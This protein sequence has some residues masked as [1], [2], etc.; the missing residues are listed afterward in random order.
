M[1]LPRGNP[2]PGLERATQSRPEKAQKGHNG[3]SR[4][5]SCT[6]SIFHV[7]ET[8]ISGWV[9]GPQFKIRPPLRGL[10]TLKLPRLEHAL[11]SA[12]DSHRL[13][14]VSA[15]AGYGKSTLLGDWAR[16]SGLNCA[17]LSLDRFDNKPERLFH[18]VV[19]ALQ[20]AASKLPVPGNHVLLALDQSLARDRAASYDLLLGALEHLTE[21]IVLVIDDTH[22]A[23][24]D[25]AQGIV[26]VLAASAPT[27]LR[28]VLSG[29]GHPSIQLERLRY[30]EGVGE[31]HA[32]EL[33]FTWQ[34]VA[35]LASALGQDESFDAGSLWQTTSGWPVAVH[36]SLATLAQARKLPDRNTIS[37][38]T[39][40]PLADYVAEE[41]LDQLDPS[42]ADFVLRAT[43]CDWISRRLADELYGRPGGGM[44]LQ[45]CLRNGLFIEEHDYRAGE[46][47]YRWHSLFAVQCRRILERR[48]PVLAERLHRVAA[49]Y[50]QDE[51]VCEC[52]AQ[53]VQGHAPGL[54][55]TSLGVHW[56]EFL[57]HTDAHTLERVCRELPPPWS[58][59]P[60]ILMIRSVC[61]A[62]AGDST[63]ASEFTQRSLAG[64]SVLDTANRLKLDSSEGLSEA[65]A[66]GGRA[67]LRGAAEVGGS[68]VGVAADG[69]P[70]LYAT[71]L[72]LLGHAEV[73]PVREDEPVIAQLQLTGT[74]GNANPLHGMEVYAK[75]EL[76]LAFAAAG[77]VVNADKQ[78]AQA[79]ESAER[80]GGSS[81]ERMAAAWLAR[82]IACYW[83]DEL[84]DARAHLV[85]A[86]RLAGKLFPLAPLGV[87]YRVLVD[88]AAGDQTHLAV[89][90]AVL[91][92]YH[93]RGL[94]GVSWTA[95]HTIAEAKVAEAEGDL[96][97]ALT[98]VRPLGAG[99]YAPLV[100]T[101][102]AELLRRGGETA[103]ARRCARSLTS[104][105]RNS[106]IDTSMSL[107]EALLAHG[108]GDS[109][110]AHERIEHASF[111]AEPQSLVRPFTDRTDEL[112]ELLRKHAVWGTT[113]E[114]FIA[115]RMARRAPGHTL[116]TASRWSLTER[117][118]EVLAY[119]RSI[120]TAAEI[121][122]ALFISV[123]TVK[124]HERSIYRK[125]G[126]A[127]RR[128]ALKMAAERGIV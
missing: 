45:E 127:S 21:R 95:F 86:L 42:L 85:R 16:N 69:N 71:G 118:R 98:I 34:E 12:A 105:R 32:D 87:L 121:A 111:R 112:A 7:E 11:S 53:A 39:H 123:N 106:Y 5:L 70:T 94:Y 26:G 125:L 10:D 128:D 56:L 24:P 50:Y 35:Q 88:C 82:G 66:V 96:D 47:K 9:P 44:C 67:G 89:S 49:H 74:I 126:A 73:R 108:S 62:L 27:A 93:D 100:D 65:L 81:Q 18:G 80:L 122:E 36:A 61:R 13:T 8:P 99:G 92:S 60:E 46:S 107:T 38:P 115:A 109:A 63:A 41:V 59:D 20:F 33:A 57:L 29:R 23:G 120:M 113:H 37:S 30:G 28:L 103:A 51:D 68:L 52:V 48:D 97:R 101:L 124:T 84:N 55:V 14:L 76:A 40:L 58:E 54:A 2:D 75:A 22:L 6:P 78:G 4:A 31:L 83:K 91:A 114:S 25:M 1:I 17:W 90:S 15:P 104:R 3:P 102:L 116:G 64:A 19:G 117:E 110:T 119:M 72:Y 43:T 77:D 79:L